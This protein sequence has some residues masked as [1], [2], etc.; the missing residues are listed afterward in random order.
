MVSEEHFLLKAVN[1]ATYDPELTEEDLREGLRSVLELLADK[2][3]Y[4]DP[5]EELDRNEGS[6]W[7]WG[8]EQAMHDVLEALAD[9]WG[10]TLNEEETREG[11]RET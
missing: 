6:L 8:Y 11:D 9:E 1:K 10:V 7:Q 3:T 5:P 2:D 4:S